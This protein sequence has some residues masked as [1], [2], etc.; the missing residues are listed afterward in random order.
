MTLS[1]VLTDR[2]VLM[3][4]LVCLFLAAFVQ[5][6]RAGGVE[7]SKGSYTSEGRTVSF[8]KFQPR[9]EGK[10][11]AVL[12]LHG[13]DGMFFFREAYPQAARMLAAQGYV[14]LIVH[15]FERT[16]TT[17]A[18]A[19]SMTR[20]FTAWMKAVGDAVT[21]VSRL[22]NVDPER[23]GLLGISLGAG[24]ALCCGGTDSR[25]KAVVEYFGGLP[26][27]VL[28]LAKRMPPVLILHGDADPI[29][30]VREAYKLEKT[31]KE[32][33]ITYEMRIYPGQGHGFTGR[34]G[35]DSR[36]RALAFFNKY[37]KGKTQ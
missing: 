3:T 18:D 31:F 29:V 2:T 30:P 11:P 9:G 8:E 34:D 17:F 33:K 12:M 22:P 21:Y 24:L 37:L 36:A 25:V 35:E 16:G 6:S 23:I 7:E 10:Y 19:N 14:V 4:L 32:K 28:A 26:D 1:N 13:A 5:K 27:N 20:N 15:Y